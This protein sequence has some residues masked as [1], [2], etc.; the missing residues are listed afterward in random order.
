MRTLADVYGTDVEIISRSD[1]VVRAYCR[2]DAP[3]QVHQLLRQCGFTS[4]ES[5]DLCCYQLP[6]Y[7]S[8]PDRMKAASMATDRLDEAGYR[9][10]IVPHLVVGYVGENCIVQTE[11]QRLA[12]TRRTPAA[13]ATPKHSGPPAPPSVRSAARTR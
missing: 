9:V 2:T 12:A 13:G 7:L 6:D 10:G 8:F 4:S 3:D 5:H 11:V 1:Q